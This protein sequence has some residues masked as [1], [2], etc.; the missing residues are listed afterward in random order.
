MSYQLSGAQERRRNNEAKANEFYE[1]VRKQ[2]QELRDLQSKL[3]TTEK[4]YADYQA[5]KNEL[6]SRMRILASSMDTTNRGLADLKNQITSKKQGIERDQ[7][8]MDRFQSEVVRLDRE[9]GELMR[10]RP[11]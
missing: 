11:S 4:L 3:A 7:A 8:E 5:Q 1:K 10:N 2:E 9:I 6:D